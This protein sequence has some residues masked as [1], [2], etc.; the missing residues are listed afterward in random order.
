MTAHASVI[1]AA[2]GSS[3]R[4]EGRDKLWVPLAGRIVLARTIDVFEA[5]QIIENIVLVLHSDRLEDASR[6]CQKDAAGLRITGI[7]SPVKQVG[8]NW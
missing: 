1:I 7:V 6:L 3:R 8:F 4:M 2:A 5:S